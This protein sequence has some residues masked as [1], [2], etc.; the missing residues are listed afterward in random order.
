MKE[1]TITI[2]TE[3]G[4]KQIKA[5]VFGQFAVHYQA[6]WNTEDSEFYFDKN[7]YSVTHV[8]TGRSIMRVIE[9]KKAAV[10]FARMVNNHFYPA[11]LE[12]AIS[13]DKQESEAFAR[14]IKDWYN[15]YGAIYQY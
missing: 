13:G 15:L 2:K 7:W 4:D 1:R 12:R 14:L 6:S 5:Q 3:S 8:E 11:R 9:T 10:A